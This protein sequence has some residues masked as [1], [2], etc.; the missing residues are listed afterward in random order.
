MGLEERGGAGA[1]VHKWHG[2]V[3]LPTSWSAVGGAPAG[4]SRA[5]VANADEKRSDA[6]DSGCQHS[7]GDSRHTLLLASLFP[8][9]KQDAG[10]VA[11]LQGDL[12]GWVRFS[13]VQYPIVK[14]DAAKAS[15]IR[16]GT[17]LQLDQPVQMIVPFLSSAQPAPSTEVGDVATSLPMFD[18]LLVLGT[19]GRVGI[20]DL[21]NGCPMG[22]FPISLK[23]LEIGCAVQTLICVSSLAMLIYCASGSAFVCRGTDLL[24]KAQPFELDEKRSVDDTFTA[25]AEKLPLQSKA[26]TCGEQIVILDPDMLAL[27]DQR[28]LSVSCSLAFC[29]SQPNKSGDPNINGFKSIKQEEHLSFLI[30]LLQDRRFLFAQLSQPIEQDIPV[31]QVAINAA[32]R[33]SHDPFMPVSR[34]G[35]TSKEDDSCSLALWSG[36]QYWAALADHAQKNPSF[37]S[38]WSKIASSDVVPVALSPPSRFVISIPSFFLDESDDEA[39]DEDE[40]FEKVRIERMVSFLRQVLEVPVDEIARL[41]PLVLDAINNWNDGVPLGISDDDHSDD[42]ALDMSEVL[43]PIVALENILEVCS[44]TPKP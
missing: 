38:L 23:T 21:K 42:L 24:A 41:R 12:D 7:D 9:V 17:L 43:E 6:D 18:A 8:E 31:S 20:V 4:R 33:Q 39:D 5:D 25:C 13:L 30:P 29:P 40:D 26:F 22:I 36:V 16:S 28:S 15:V 10:V 34:N 37:A 14:G 44:T 35:N 19:R 27:Q 11:I 1:F 3:V 2:A 32:F